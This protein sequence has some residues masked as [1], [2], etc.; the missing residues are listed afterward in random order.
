M[1]ETFPASPKGKGD[2]RWAEAKLSACGFLDAEDINCFDK[3]E[4]ILKSQIQ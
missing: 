1:K 3:N 2:D 4:L